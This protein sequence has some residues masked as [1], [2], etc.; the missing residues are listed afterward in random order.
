MLD[1][2]GTP[3]VPQGTKTRAGLVVQGRQDGKLNR[4]QQVQVSPV[5]VTANA[6]L[7]TEQTTDLAAR[8]HR[9]VHVFLPAVGDL[10]D[11][12]LRGWV[13]HVELS[14]ARCVAEDLRWN[15]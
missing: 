15:V 10:R 1:Y 2:G 12:F 13:Y 14:T 11:Q 3:A 9:A 5:A 8:L 4:D 7:P 6:H